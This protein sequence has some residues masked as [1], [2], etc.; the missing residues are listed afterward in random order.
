VEDKWA[1]E[2]AEKVEEEANQRAQAEALTKKQRIAL[3]V[4]STFFS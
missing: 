4:P 3:Q 2:Q 1:Q